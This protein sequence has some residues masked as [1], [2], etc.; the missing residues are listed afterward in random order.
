MRDAADSTHAI[1]AEDQN[2]PLPGFMQRLTSTNVA[3]LNLNYL[4]DNI[5]N[6]TLAATVMVAG[7]WLF[8]RGNHILS[9][10]YIN[11]V[12]GAHIVMCG[13]ILC[14]LNF[15]HSLKTIARTPG[16]NWPAY[17]VF[18]TLLVG[19]LELVGVALLKFLHLTQ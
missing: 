12:F 18:I 15:A 7:I 2:T 16:K 17:I 9:T 19:S 1:E 11:W 4:F 13:L 6:Y 10:P 14:G 3:P 8:T 5:R